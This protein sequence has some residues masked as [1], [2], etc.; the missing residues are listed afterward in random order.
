LKRREGHL[1]RGDHFAHSRSGRPRG[2]WHPLEQHL[3]DTAQAASDASRKW[4]A[5]DLAY[6]AGLWHDLGKYAP[7]WQDFLLEAG[8]DA[9]V[10][11]EEQPANL[12]ARRHGPDHSTAGAIHALRRFGPHE[13]IGI[14]LQFA[15]AGHHA[16]LA[17]LV[18][19]RER[20]AKP[21]KLT[22]YEASASEAP[23]DL[24][25]ERL[26][27]KLP[28]FMLAAA[29]KERAQ[30][31]FE[32]FVRMLFSALVDADYLD[33]ERFFDAVGDGASRRLQRRQWQRIETYWPPIEAHLQNLAARPSTPVIEQRRRVLGWCLDAAE[34]PRGAYTLTVPTGGGKTL[35]S[36]A[37]AVKH[38]IHHWLERVIVAVPYIS[39]LDQTADVF[40][41]V[42]APA[43]GDPVLVEHHSNVVPE[44]DTVVNRLASENWDAPLIV[45]TQV[46]LFESL[47]SN[48]P[49]DCRKL[50]RLANS[51]IVLDE[52]QTL[53]A[54]LLAAILDQLQELKAHYG[55]S[56]LLTT[57]TQ[58]A[59]HS[60]SLGPRV[61]EGLDPVPREIVPVSEIGALFDALSS[62]VEVIWPR[63]DSPVSWPDL[64]QR[65]AEL[66]QVLAIVHTRA[67]ARTLW[68]ECRKLGMDSAVHLSALMCP[69]HRRRVLGD[70]RHRLDAGLPCRVVST[71]LVEAGVDVDFPAV[72]RAMAGLESLAQ[73]AGRCN[74]E[75]RLA[76]GCFHVFNALSAPPGLLALHR[77]V[78]VIMR[79][80]DPDLQLMRPETFR[81]YFDRL[82]AMR[83][84]DPRGIQA[85]RETLRFEETAKAFRMIDD[86]GATVFVPYGEEGRSAIEDF[87]R[88]GPSLERFRS[89]QPFS[90]SIYPAAL[91][92][93]QAR[94]A[95][96]TLHS[97]VAVLVSEVDYDE[98]LGL[99]TR[100][101]PYRF[102]SV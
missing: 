4:G 2:E 41:S 48:R 102:L 9:P 62:R 19:L 61:F 29:S 21:E 43:L 83:G 77:E 18:P 97:S 56:L 101:E 1:S 94:G 67:D 65:L 51:V 70:I 22:R 5:G 32:T 38:A 68:E 93:L 31:R 27:P 14:A 12:P 40:R 96:E 11:G 72:F 10:L 63:E 45:T 80:A 35:S 15:I 30:R 26:D 47:F 60:R 87:R 49:R 34:G 55:A 17:D 73:S 33:T 36:L 3:R 13:R 69:G 89:L 39:I 98:N 7:D 24:L 84:P 66:D 6:L 78:A 42:F 85:L 82:Y 59:L 99:L 64:A 46:Q 71:S 81:A 37:F 92:E 90:V 74:R 100:P 88:S 91:R 28:P 52:V 58:P 50:H 8:E 79:R 44:H 57:A 54:E 75:G 86:S 53:P 23:A 16:G 95:V 20:I 25:D 76:R